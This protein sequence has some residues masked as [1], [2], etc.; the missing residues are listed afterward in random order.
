M[1]QKSHLW[2]F[3]QKNREQG[4]EETAVPTFTVVSST[5]AK[6]WKPPGVRRQTLDPR[7][8]VCTTH[9]HT[10]SLGLTKEGN[11]VMGYH[12]DGPGG[13]YAK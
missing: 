1:T 8:A 5:G 6:R 11:L 2:E 7:N 13:H 9:T 3:I 10:P 4:L 12:T